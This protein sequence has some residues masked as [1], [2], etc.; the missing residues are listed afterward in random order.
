[1]SQAVKVSDGLPADPDNQGWVK[2]WGVFRD[3]PWNL[4]AVCKTE[5]DG[6]QALT[7]VGSEY[8]VAFGS[9]KLGSDDFVAEL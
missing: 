8:Q 9:H 3:N 6:S 4:Y 2:G 1:V 5:Q 7:E